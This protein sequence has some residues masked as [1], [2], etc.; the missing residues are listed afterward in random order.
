MAAR[1]RWRCRQY[2]VRCRECCCITPAKGAVG[3]LAG[4]AVT[5]QPPGMLDLQHTHDGTRNKEVVK[6]N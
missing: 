4:R 2:I 6:M 1:V 3:A 5:L